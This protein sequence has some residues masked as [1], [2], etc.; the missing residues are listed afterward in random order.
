MGVSV[1]V[2]EKVAVATTG[3][4]VAVNGGAQAASAALPATTPATLIKS[5]R[6]RL[7]FFEV[8]FDEIKVFFMGFSLKSQ[9]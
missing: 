3:V 4:E 9:G 1:A 7:E 8:F 6:E 5:R 2:G